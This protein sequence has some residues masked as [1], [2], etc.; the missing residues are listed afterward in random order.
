MCGIFHTLY[1]LWG[2]QVFPHGIGMFRNVRATFTQ[3]FHVELS[4][5]AKWPKWLHSNRGL[6]GTQNLRST[7][8]CWD[9]PHID[10]VLL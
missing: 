3:T 2:L 10:L 4:Q 8:N 6:A 5:G 7:C 9:G 1:V